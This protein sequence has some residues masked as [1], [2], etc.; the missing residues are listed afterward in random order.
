MWFET[1]VYKKLRYGDG[2]GSGLRQVPERVAGATRER[3]PPHLSSGEG[4]IAG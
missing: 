1:T 2:C 3:R 4:L